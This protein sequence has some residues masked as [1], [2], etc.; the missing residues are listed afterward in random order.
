MLPRAPGSNK[1]RRSDAVPTVVPA[2]VGGDNRFEGR[3]ALIRSAVFTVCG[4]NRAV[5]PPGPSLLG[6][7]LD[8]PAILGDR[9]GWMA[10]LFRDHG[11]VVRV[12][13]GLRT[14]YAVFH[15][16]HFHHVLALNAR[17]YSK[18][19]TFEKTAA[20]MGT[21][22][23]TA[24]GPH[25]QA[26]RR[27]MNPHF[28]RT[29]LKNL[30]PAMVANIDR[31]LDRWAESARAGRLI[32]LSV[33][34]QRFAM[35]TVARTLFGTRIP[36]HQIEKAIACIRTVLHHT[37]RRS[38]S[39]FDF[40]GHLPLP[41]N[42]RFRA[43]VRA[44]D[45]IV[46]GIIREEQRA[47][48]ASGTLLAALVQARDPE[49]GAAMTTH[50][51]RDEVMT[52]FLGGTDT[53][54][55]TLGWVFYNLARYP[56]VQRRVRDEVAALGSGPLVAEHLDRLEYTRRVIEETLRLFPQNWAGARDTVAPDTIGGFDIPAHRT[57]F[58]GVHVV[59][60]R[61]DFWEHPEAFDP[62]RFLP[63]KQAGRH[64]MQY[65]PFGAGSRKCIGYNFAMMEICLC[66]AG[67]LRRFEF[68]VHRPGAIVPHPAWS[69][70]PRPGVPVRLRER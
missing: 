29:A 61:P 4:V 11:D 14:A 12:P 62:D 34:F 33:E 8:L 21:G 2:R 28:T 18:G 70:A 55:N 66:V 40:V 6:V 20:F 47:L 52:L 19:R 57:V 10:R 54:G 53:T 25:W 30:A 48:E 36:E 63:E 9:L 26:Q 37:A 35:E 43:A 59:H 5:K 50:Q 17:G 31:T 23:A 46:Y 24:E 16:D 32:D 45:A 49:T 13:M 1:Y 51:L 56:E 41:S 22:L 64:P 42:R 67:V 60:R 58:L 44:L 69:L 15:P 27:R 7:L 38:L 39:P 68:E 65:I 3:P